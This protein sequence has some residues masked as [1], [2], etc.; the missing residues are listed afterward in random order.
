MTARVPAGRLFGRWAEQTLLTLQCT[1]LQITREV[2]RRLP[3][4]FKDADGN[5]WH[6]Q[7]RM[8]KDCRLWM[9]HCFALIPDEVSRMRYC[10]RI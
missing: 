8:S 9:K 2:E 1:S 5:A 4:A 3:V 10:G 7:I 6:I